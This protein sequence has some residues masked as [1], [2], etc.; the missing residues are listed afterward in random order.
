MTVT[1]DKNNSEKQSIKTNSLPTNQLKLPVIPLKEGLLF[2][3]TES[4]LTF[5]RKISIAGLKAASK[6]QKKLVILVAQKKSTINHPRP[7]SLYTVGTLAVIERT[8][9]T[10]DTINALVRGIGRV[11]IKEFTQKS[12]FLEAKAIRLSDQEVNDDETKALANHLQKT[13]RQTVQMGKA[14]EFLN[15]M[16]LLGGVKAGELADQIASTLNLST[17]IKQSILEILDVKQRLKT[18][19]HHLSREI[20]ILEIEKDVVF[21]TQEKFDK[22]MRESVLRERLRTIQK[23]L[24]EIDD[25]DELADSYFTKLKKLKVDQEKKK[26]IKKEIKRLRQMSPNNPETGYIRSWLDTIFELPWGI[27]TNEKVDLKEAQKVLDLYHYGLE[28][29]KDRVL[30]YIA[31]LQLKQKNKAED[32][33]STPTILCFA[34]PP[35]VGKTSIGKSIAESLGRKFVKVSL[36]GIRDE[37]EIRGHR[38]TYVGAMTGKIISGMKQAQSMNPVFMLDEVD[39]IGNDFRGDPAAALLE[40]LDPEQNK[41]FVDHYLDLPFDLSKAIFITTANTLDT[42]PPALRDRLEIIN[43]S[44]YTP[45]EKFHIVKKH[46]L[47][48]VIK[49]NGLGKDNIEIPDDLIKKIISGYTREAGVRSLERTIH[50][51]ARKVAKTLITDSKKKKVS[52]KKSDLKKLLGPQK[53]DEGLAEKEDMI[54]AAT[55]LAWTAVGGDV[56]FVEVALTPGKGKIQI[57]GQLGDV[58]KESA[59]AALT[60]VKSNLKKLKIAENKINKTDIHI[61]VPEGAV[62]KDGPSAGVT[63]TTAIVSALT[64]I[65][66][67]RTVAMTGEITLRGKVLRIGGLKE[68]SIAAHQA[69]I[70]TVIIPKDNQRDLEKIPKTVKKSITFKPVSS[71]NEVIKIAL[72]KTI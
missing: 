27:T 51:I 48:K 11:K 50:S 55:G 33:D 63:L 10:D 3:V 31:V 59:Q 43:Y 49:A 36:G 66:V 14:V 70:K 45:E 4:V 72:A 35:G 15:F 1:S 23:E 7:T 40:V 2:P 53:F 56:L 62:P 17:Q 34:G 69:G 8:I 25:E 30:E 65:P 20:K 46:L 52:L 39:K 28:D 16:K 21:K 44:G 22:H 57:T 12:P 68:K 42:I 61:H 26:I 13:F 47:E 54:G 18:V 38:K 67:K 41:G 37:A 5:G 32:K 9:K 71:V 29:V 60:Y 19:A 24:G 6:N 64:K 58:M